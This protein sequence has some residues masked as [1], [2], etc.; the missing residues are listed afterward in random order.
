MSFG[1]LKNPRTEF[2]TFDVVDMIYPY[3]TIFERG[4]LNTFKAA[5]HS[6]YLCL[7]IPA[8]FG[9]I[10]IFGSQQEARN[11]KKDF[12]PGHK[13]VHL[14]REDPAQHTTFADQHK[15]E[16]PAECKIAIE[17]KG[18]FE[19]VPLDQRVPDRTV[20]ISVEASQQEHTELLAFL[21]KNSDVF[22]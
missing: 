6:T 8:T 2:I 17:P 10:S 18:E 1:T 21:D 4:L 3:N 22:T 11:I 15:A 9:V 7:K 19:K 5:L 14:L 20:C 12:T 13:N 16:A